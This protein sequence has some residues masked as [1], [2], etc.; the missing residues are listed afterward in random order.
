MRKKFGKILAFI[1]ALCF[2][3]GLYGVSVLADNGDGEASPAADA[4]PAV[5]A[6]KGGTVLDGA[7]F[8]FSAVPQG[9]KIGGLSDDIVNAD[10]N[11]DITVNIDLTNNSEQAV[12]INTFKI[13]LD[14]ASLSAGLSFV[15]FK[16][17]SDLQG[18]YIF[19]TD[20]TTGDPT[21]C[22]YSKELSDEV[23]GPFTL[24]ASGGSITVATVTLHVGDEANGVKLT[25]G[26]ILDI[27]LLKNSSTQPN[28]G[29]NFHP[30]G[31]TYAVTPN[32]VNGQVEIATTYTIKLYS[33]EEDYQEL[34]VGVNTLP[35][36][37][38]DYVQPEKPGSTFQGWDPEMAVASADAVYTAVWSTLADV[39]FADYKYAN[40]YT[41]TASS[42]KLMLAGVDSVS[43]GSALCY[44]GAP[45]FTTTDANY[46]A[47]LNAAYEPGNLSNGKG[48]TSY[49]IAYIYVVPAD[50]TVNQGAAALS[51]GEGANTA[52]ARDGN[53]NYGTDGRGDQI[54]AADFGIVDD[55][56]YLYNTYDDM[57]FI[58]EADVVTTDGNMQFG[59]IDDVITI[60]NYSNGITPNP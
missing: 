32:T 42:G 5:N 20:A 51:I 6:G 39:V 55:L 18:S 38:P 40:G 16:A 10:I 22:Y 23:V 34:T 60:I 41:A 59:T 11:S 52:V 9:T 24:A 58:L 2:S 7:S 33:S 35:T 14:L 25:Y 53:V 21:C 31:A 8:T 47:L 30:V 57:R 49:T 45:M 3:L 27:K 4:K 46:L 44:N 13:E 15:S 29:S 36:D 28:A 48:V 56:L 43:E 12:T 19:A 37:H 17:S 50:L 1:F 54:D 26:D